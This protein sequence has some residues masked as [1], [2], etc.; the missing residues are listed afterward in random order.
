MKYLIYILLMCSHISL[1]Q[2]AFD[3]GNG[4]YRAGRYQEAIVSYESILKSGQESGE[5]YFNLGNAYYKLDKVAPAVYNYEKALLLNPDNKQAAINLGF[6]Q[7]MAIDNIKQAPEA[8][9]SGF[10]NKFTGS[11]HYDTWAWAAVGFSFGFLLLFAGYYL[12]GKTLLKRVY[13]A[14]MGIMALGILISLFSAYFIKSAYDS[15]RPAIIFNEVLSVKTEPLNSA[16]DAFILH[17]G[18][19]VYITESLDNW[20]RIKLADNTEGWVSK[21]ALK[22]LKN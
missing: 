19:K 10:I 5:V 18:T 22:E 7:K 14:G 12:A 6:A 13:F 3:K 11:Y 2:S 17:E 15:Q 20:H 16:Q 8:G 9:F 1:G 21:D 4:Q